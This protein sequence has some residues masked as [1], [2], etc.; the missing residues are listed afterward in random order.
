V[1]LV[2]TSV[3]VDYFNGVA[4]P[5]VD[6]LHDLL[7]G[8]ELVLGDVIVMEILR[9]FRSERDAIRAEAALRRYDIRSLLGAEAA[10]I[11][12]QHYRYL[13]QRGVTI[14]KSNDVVIASWCLSQACGLL[15]TD[16][17]FDPFVEWLGL[18]RVS[19]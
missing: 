4:S 17:N 11:A 3:W 8:A 12:A 2:D 16:R 7:A 19:P 18:R 6:A 13:R 14:R 10:V 9:G 5:E 15:Y 1:I